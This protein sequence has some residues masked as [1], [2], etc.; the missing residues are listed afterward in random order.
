MRAPVASVT[1][2]GRFGADG[3]F[4]AEADGFEF[5]AGNAQRDERIFGGGG[6]AIAKREIVFSGTTFVAMA[7]DGN[8]KIRI[9]LENGFEGTGVALQN[10]LIFAAY[11]AF[12]VIE[13]NV[14]YLL[15]QDLL[16]SWL[17]GG[18]NGCRGWGRAYCHGG[19]CPGC[20]AGSGG[21][22]M[23]GSCG[24]WINATA[25]IRAHFA[26]A[27]V[28]RDASGIGNRPAEGRGLAYGDGCWLSAEVSDRGFGSWV[29]LR[30]R[31]GS[32]GWRRRDFLFTSSRKPEHQH[33]QKRERY[34]VFC[35]EFMQSLQIPI[36]SILNHFCAL[37]QTGF[38]LP[39]VSVRGC[40][41]V[42]SAFITQICD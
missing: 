35:H 10:R 5:V 32:R 14:L 27:I 17:T 2:F 42:P 40:L 12:V 11:F 23:I 22:Q 1:V 38:S 13:V 26:N 21:G 20:A 37:T 39:P 16:D 3:T 6:A 34:F 25:A 29:V 4:F 28:N 9:H 41:P 18:G 7:F 36:F 15:R 30:D 31:G 24:S 8:D 33:C 19:I